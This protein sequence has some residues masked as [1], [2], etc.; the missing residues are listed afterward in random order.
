MHS[1]SWVCLVFF[2]PQPFTLDHQ[3]V[4]GHAM[5]PAFWWPMA[6]PMAGDTVSA[7]NA[8]P[9]TKESL[10]ASVVLLSSELAFAYRLEAS[11][12]GLDFRR[13]ITTRHV[14]LFIILHVIASQVHQKIKTK[15]TFT[16]NSFQPQPEPAQ[17]ACTQGQPRNAGLFW[18]PKQ[19]EWEKNWWKKRGKP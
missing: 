14:G 4:Q 10:Q 18:K 19:Y 1:G 3:G 8:L 17:L 11:G 5:R 2:C 6:L 7:R 13:F 12:I 9:L 16:V 15:K